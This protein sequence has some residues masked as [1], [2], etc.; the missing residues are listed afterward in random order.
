MFLHSRQGSE[1]ATVSAASTAN[2][3]G[4]ADTSQ[5]LEPPGISTLMLTSSHHFEFDLGNP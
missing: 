2:V 1:V 5:L 3:L 4:F